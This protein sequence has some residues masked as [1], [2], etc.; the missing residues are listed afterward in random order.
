MLEKNAVILKKPDKMLLIVI[1]G[2]RDERSFKFLSLNNCI[3]IIIIFIPPVVKISGVK[4]KV[5]T[6]FAGVALVQ[7]GRNC[8]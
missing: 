1:N 3:I 4:T 2:E 7:F 8:K 6:K 5:K